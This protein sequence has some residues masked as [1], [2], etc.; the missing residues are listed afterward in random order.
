MSASGTPPGTGA[1]AKAEVH[2]KPSDPIKSAARQHR[3]AMLKQK[4]K[5]TSADITKYGV[6]SPLQLLSSNLTFYRQN[7]HIVEYNRLPVQ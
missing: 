3:K 4:I 6:S 5:P 1:T 7:S 2:L